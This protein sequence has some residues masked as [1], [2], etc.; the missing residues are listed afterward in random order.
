M[1]KLVVWDADGTLLQSTEIAWSV[2]ELILE[3]ILGWRPEV[4]SASAEHQ[5]FGASHLDFVAPGQGDAV[6]TMHRL[7]MLAR[8]STIELVPGIGTVVQNV[9]AEQVV[10]SAAL[11]EYVTKALGPLAKS[12]SAIRG[13][14]HG[15]KQQLL[16]KYCDQNAVYVTDTVRDVLLCRQIGLS[17]VAVSWGLDGMEQLAAAQPDQLVE[18][19]TELQRLLP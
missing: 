12:F 19:P 9:T 4:R 7:G 11:S 3:I 15:P 13:H 14:D 18:S 5:L 2:I 10:V 16:V 17:V 8:A 6:R 1:K